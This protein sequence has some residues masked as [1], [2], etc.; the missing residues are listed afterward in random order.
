MIARRLF[1]A[2]TIS[3]MLA[4]GAVQ[5]KEPPVEKAAVLIAVG[6]YK[7]TAVDMKTR[8]VTLQDEDGN[9]ET[10][11]IGEEARNLDQVRVGDIVTVKSAEGIAVEVEPHSGG[12]LGMIERTG[13]SRSD[14][15]QKPHAAV[16][17]HIELIGRIES[18]DSKKREVTIRGKDGIVTVPVADDVD[19]DKV[20][21]GD[22]VRVDILEAVSI[23]VNSP[24]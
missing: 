10:F 8:K 23:T 22:T 9:T 6:T 15:G 1:A 18:L 17:K 2:A 21:K 20:R 7:V 4:G 16:Y 3:L 12:V 19:L 24:K 5:A 11:T 13:V 14:K